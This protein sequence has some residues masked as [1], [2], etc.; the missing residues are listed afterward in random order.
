MCL[1]DSKSTPYDR[2]FT[3]HCDSRA[4]ALCLDT[5]IEGQGIDF[6]FHG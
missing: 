6:V 3:K 1:H 4:F 5:D 2:V